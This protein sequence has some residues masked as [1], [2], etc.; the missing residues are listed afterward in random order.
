M[1]PGLVAYLAP[2]LRERRWTLALILAPSA[3][4]ALTVVYV[5]AS[6]AQ[7]LRIWVHLFTAL[8]FAA[9][10]AVVLRARSR[11][12]RA[13]HGWLGLALLT[14]PA[15]A[16]LLAATR[17]DPVAIRYWAVI[18]VV[19][20]GLT[21][22]SVSLHRR[23]RRLVAEVARRRDAEQ[24]LTAMNGTLEQRI[25]ERTA[26]LRN[27]VAGLE[28]FNRSV[29]HDL[30]DPLSS[31]SGL[32]RLAGERLAEGQLD[33]VRAALPAIAEQA[34][35]S[36]RLVATLLELARVGEAE[37]RRQR[38]DPAAIAREVIGQ[39]AASSKTPLPAI[40]VRQLPEVDADPE[41]LRP[42]FVN[43]I[44]NAIKFSAASPDARIVI[45]ADPAT[46]PSGGEASGPCLFV[47]DNGVGF[48]ADA[49]GRL[50]T[51]YSRLHGKQFEGHGI[52]LS[53]VRRAV[54]RQGGR[55]WA[56]PGPGRGACF[57]FTLPAAR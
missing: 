4:F 26:D 13:G 24:A 55:V 56:E 2:P 15:L 37:V 9:M 16:V 11:E 5:A 38:T 32:A 45:G 14:V 29:S 31:I 36:T 8:A 6:G 22:P 17:T 47:C 51:P 27:M 18:P 19:L 7:V 50:F 42:V 52:G 28:T 21:L 33:F 35:T 49:A 46:T 48:G 41:L 57:K 54:E 40:E 23:Q 30:R 25:A 53:I 10:G 20:V 3:A 44:G 34:D 39:I 43:L 1:A 12:P